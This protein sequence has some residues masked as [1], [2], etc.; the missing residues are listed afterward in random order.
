MTCGLRTGSH[1]SAEARLARW[2]GGVLLDE[3][4]RDDVRLET[5]D[6]RERAARVSDIILT[7]TIL[8]A[9]AIRAVAIPLARGDREYARRATIAYAVAIGVTLAL[10][11][12]IKDSARRARPF[13]RDCSRSPTLAGCGS[14]DSLASFYSLHAATAFTSVGFSWALAKMRPPHDARERSGDVV[15]R[16]RAPS[17]PLL[18]SLASAALTGLLRIASDRHYLSDVLIGAAMGLAVGVLVPLALLPDRRACEGGAQ[19][20]RSVPST[21]RTDVMLVPASNVS[22]PRPAVIVKA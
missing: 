20:P 12:V 9:A 4:V 5:H 7:A 13:E 21:R 15:A 8:D 19:K 16:G 22:V 1:A 11:R 17:A 3:S 14:P 10:G 6:E 2:R 18:A